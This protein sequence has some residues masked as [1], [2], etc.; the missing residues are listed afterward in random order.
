[1]RS[2]YEEFYLESTTTNELSP[3]EKRAEKII[4]I[5]LDSI[6][7]IKSKDFFISINPEGIPTKPIN[8][9]KNVND[10]RKWLSS[11]D[12]DEVERN[13]CKGSYDQISKEYITDEVVFQISI[14][15]KYKNRG[16]TE[17]LI[18][19]Q[20][21]EAKWL[22]TKQSIR[23]VIEK[24]AT[25]Y[26]ELNKPFI[27][28][29]NVLALSC[30]TTDVMEALFGTEK[31]IYRYI[32]NETYPPIVT[33]ENDGKFSKKIN[34]RLSGIMIIEKF[35]PWN[36]HVKIPVLYLNPWAKFPYE[37]KLLDLPHYYPE[38]G[39]IKFNPGNDYKSFIPNDL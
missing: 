31:Y 4:N 16:E 11:L 32:E 2:E 38:G 28:A 35:N 33:R 14:I 29:I 23:K 1:M 9:K 27:L 30:D 22:N 26:G 34:T 25:R 8:G 20:M 19:S 15:P 6:N 37:G 18:G 36:I 21:Y 7:E 3:K 5:F 39:E 12:Y 13:F 17:R 24:K 10:L